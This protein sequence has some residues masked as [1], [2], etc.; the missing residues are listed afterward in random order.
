MSGG[1]LAL[2]LLS[3]CALSPATGARLR[4][5]AAGEFH[6]CG[7]LGGSGAALCFG[8]STFGALAPPAATAFSSLAAG[9]RHS[10][11]VR[12]ADG[13]IACWGNN[14]NGQ[15]S[16]PPGGA[17]LAR[18]AR[19]AARVTRGGAALRSRCDGAGWWRLPHVFPPS[20]HGGRV[21]RDGLRGADGAPR[22]RR[23]RVP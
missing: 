9:Q 4:L 18:W 8:D 6:G 17:P 12:A 20:R 16:P 22:V 15:C 19:A 13:G 5:L 10:C 11:G 2:L 1:V 23:R 7:V 14:V 21:L 3:G